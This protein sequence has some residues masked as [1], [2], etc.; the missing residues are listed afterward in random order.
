MSILSHDADL[1]PDEA[2]E[3]LKRQ[4]ILKMTVA[5]GAIV[6]FVVVLAQRGNHVLALMRG[7]AP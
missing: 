5:L 1:S 6:A 2:I 7:V 4:R 3:A